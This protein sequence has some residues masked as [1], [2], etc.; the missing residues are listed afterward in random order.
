MKCYIMR[1]I[2]IPTCHYHVCRKYRFFLWREQTFICSFS[3]IRIY[4]VWTF[5]HKRP[6]HVNVFVTL[7]VAPGHHHGIKGPCSRRFLTWEKV[8]QIF[9]QNTIQLL[10]TQKHITKLTEWQLT[11]RFTLQHFVSFFARSAKRDSGRPLLNIP[12][13]FNLL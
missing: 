10:R 2:Y 5:C 12:G 1:I 4:S 8:V 3:V 9:L 13:R 11:I 6:F 7:D